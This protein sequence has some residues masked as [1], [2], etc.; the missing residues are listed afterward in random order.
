MNEPRNRGETSSIRTSRAREA[1]TP[2]GIETKARLLEGAR[3]VLARKGVRGTTSREIAAESGVNLAGITY[4]FGSKEE[5]VAQALLETIR[6]WLDPALE[7]L[8]RDEH[9][10]VRMVGA[11]QAL[12]GSFE[13]GSEMLPVY[14]EALLHTGTVDTLRTGVRATLAELRGF[15]A[16]QITGLKAARFLP[17]WVDPE[18]MAMLLVAAGDGLALHAAVEPSSLDLHA[19]AAQAMQVLLAARSHG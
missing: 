2:G 15:L 13:A 1:A 11:M 16:E 7:A 6:S 5:L 8:R 19:V 9:P 17:A 10:V 3:R 18:A 12:Q 14:L 4:H